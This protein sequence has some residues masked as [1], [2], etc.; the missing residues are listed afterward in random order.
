MFPGV[1]AVI[2]LEA[3]DD[4]AW[5]L[6]ADLVPMAEA[7]LVP[8]MEA[9]LVRSLMLMSSVSA[10]SGRLWVLWSDIEADTTQSCLS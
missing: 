4:F 10:M 1:K 6:E 7:V 8:R 2:L 9:E 3:E 5:V